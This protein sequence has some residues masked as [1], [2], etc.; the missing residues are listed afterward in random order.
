[1]KT[2]MAFTQDKDVLSATAMQVV[3]LICSVTGMESVLV[4]IAPLVQNVTCVVK[5]SSILHQRD[6]SKCL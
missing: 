5:T 4:K 6:A 2:T 3:L 1:M